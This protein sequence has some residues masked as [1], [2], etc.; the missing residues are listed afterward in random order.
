M[1]RR[2]TAFVS[3]LVV[4][5]FA[6]A[7]AVGC[8]GDDAKPP[9]PVDPRDVQVQE[10]AP[11][12]ECPEAE[13]SIICA[14]NWAA[15]CSGAGKPDKLIN[16]RE[17]GQVCAPGLG[18]RACIPGR[19]TCGND[20]DLIECDEEGEDYFEV[21]VCDAAAGENCSLASGRCEDLCQAAVQARSYIGCEYWSVPTI[22]SQLTILDEAGE[23]TIPFT[24]AV[25]IANPQ[26]VP[27]ELTVERAGSVESERSVAPGE[28]EVIDLGWIPALVGEPAEHQ[29]SARVADG[30]YRIE[31]SVPVTV[32]QFNPLQFSEEID[33]ED[34]F[35]HSNDASLLLP[36]HALTGNYLV[37]SRPTLFNS[38]DPVPGSCGGA[39]Q[40]P[41]PD[42]YLSSTPGFVAIVGVEDEPTEV[43]IA[44]SAYTAASGDDSV[45][46]LE[47]GE[48]HTVTLAR[49][50]VLQLVSAAPGECLQDSP[51][52]RGTGLFCETDPDSGQE[53]CA[54]LPADFQYCRVEPEYDL[55]GT[56]V[57]ASGRVAVIAGHD[58]AFVPYD[59]WAC[60]HLEE[61]M[62]PLEAWGKEMY[63]ALSK[64]IRGEPNVIRVLSGSDGNRLDFTP[65]VHADVR[66]DAG[67][68]IEFESSEDFRVQGSGAIMVAQ[69]LVGQDYEGRGRAGVFSI[70]DPAM[71]LGIP[72]EQW[73]SSY[74]F[75]APETF[76]ENYVNVIAGRQQVVLLDGDLI[77]EWQ[78]MEGTYM[79]STRINIEGGRHTIE[80][81]LPFGIV[82]YGYAVYTSYMYPGGLDLREIN[83]L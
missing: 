45:P 23:A 34:L 14:G 70:G 62:F 73:R 65:G 74:T 41:C 18:C 37:M 7:L 76:P 46:A 69:F 27:A 24:F 54:E 8:S 15:F 42:P 9:P 28:L 30:A 78:P 35:T 57:R 79:F 36:T 13:D 20:N 3:V 33:G 47:P 50:E 2:A 60:D 17:E 32:Y 44:V 75:L 81:A 25:V 4:L 40:I 67:E 12:V 71:S 29:R 16:C 5:R 53:Q 68:F 38:E 49:G 59:R 1:A 55:T 61:A 56:R 11:E 72:L 77:G 43:E 52:D 19:R 64:P 26:A 58:C 6:G 63:V 31:S 39:G 10:D 51:S 82:V 66:L 21:E 80:G 48:S 22:N 83:I